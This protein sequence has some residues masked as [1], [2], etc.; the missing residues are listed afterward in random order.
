[1]TNRKERGLSAAERE[2]LRDQG[3]K[4]IPVVY[5][6][7]GRCLP[8]TDRLLVFLANAAAIRYGLASAKFLLRRTRLR[9][10]MAIW[11]G[12]AACVGATRRPMNG[13]ED[14]ICGGDRAGDGRSVAFQPVDWGEDWPVPHH[15]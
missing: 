10:A 7:Y 2:A 8:D 1:M 13:V 9:I 5:S 6:C 3:I 14:L 11:N 12:A 15:A 4:Y